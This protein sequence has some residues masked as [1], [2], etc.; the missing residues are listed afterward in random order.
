MIASS[1]EDGCMASAT[2]REIYSNAP[3]PQPVVAV[4]ED[5]YAW[6]DDDPDLAPFLATTTWRAR[7]ETPLEAFF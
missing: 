7:K 2:L 3:L 1:C 4:H 6:L 5:E